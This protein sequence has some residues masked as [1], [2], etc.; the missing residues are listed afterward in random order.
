MFDCIVSTGP[1]FERQHEDRT[2]LWEG[3]AWGK[4]PPGVHHL[5]GQ[6]KQNTI[7]GMCYRLVYG[8]LIKAFNFFTHVYD[9]YCIES[10][11][12]SILILLT[13]WWPSPA[14]WSI[15]EPWFILI[16]VFV[17]IMSF[18]GLFHISN[19]SEMNLDMCRLFAVQIFYAQLLCTVIY[20]LP[21]YVLI[22]T[23]LF[24]LLDFPLPDE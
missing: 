2:E 14:R 1:E 7:L 12:E 15:S 17:K 20:A 8:T 4:V 6:R 22:F 21:S 11:F 23:P 5:H 16:N 19:A 24:P 13:S 10:F 3:R 18:N 9:N